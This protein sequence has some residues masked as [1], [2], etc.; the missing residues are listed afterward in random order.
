MIGAVELICSAG[1]ASVHMPRPWVA[2]KSLVPSWLAKSWLIATFGSP[3][4]S[5]YQLA[6]WS[7][8]AKTPA[9]LPAIKRLALPGV[10]ST[11]SK[12]MFGRLVLI[13][14]QLAPLLV[15]R[16]TWP[17]LPEANALKVA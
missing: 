10:T 12:G 16:K 5:A 7:S 9:S 14:V 11:D 17:P 3:V 6:P 1:A 13:S 15:E 4:P 2:T 8:L